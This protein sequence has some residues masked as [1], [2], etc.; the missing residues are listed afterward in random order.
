[1]KKILNLLLIFPFILFNSCSKDD[2]NGI[3]EEKNPEIEINVFYKTNTSSQIHYDN[4]AKVF[5]YYDFDPSNIVRY[6]Y[7]KDGKLVRGD[8]AIFPDQTAIIENDGKIIINP[9]I[10]DK[11]TTIIVESKF[12]ERKLSSGSFS[13]LINGAK[14]TIY[15]NQ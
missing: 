7:E 3:V 1:M 5:I 12:Y 15:F 14:I 9:N 4:G 6:S 10:I 8:S 13:S 11:P 2:D